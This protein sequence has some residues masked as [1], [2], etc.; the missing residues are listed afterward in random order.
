MKPERHAQV[1]LPGVL[2]HVALAL[3]PPLPLAHSSTSTHALPLVMKPV[4]HEN[5]HTAAVHVALE[6]AG[7]AQASQRAPHE[8][9]AS[10][11]TH[12]WPHACWPCGQAQ[13]PAEQL[14]PEGQS[15]D[16]RQPSWHER[17]MGSQKY[18]APQ[19]CVSVVQS[20]GSTAQV[21]RLHTWP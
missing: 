4:A 17:E 3:Q 9:E 14:A 13:T 21:P 10:F 8:L 12:A 5:P 7:V 19:P 20:V 16:R 11:G 6:L 18:P 15:V 1:R 2:V